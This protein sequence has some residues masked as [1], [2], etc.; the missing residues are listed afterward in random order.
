MSTLI[1]I[2]TYNERENIV[3][4]IR[5]ILMLPAHFEV[6]VVDDNS[7]DGT[8]TAVRETFAAMPRVHMLERAKK[9]GL[10]TAY[11]AGFKFAIEKGY[12]NAITMDADFSHSPD[13]IPHLYDA[14]DANDLVIGSRYVPGGAT[15]NWGILR[16]IISRSANLMAHVVLS[17][18]PADCTSGFRLYRLE[19]LKSLDFETVIAD[20]YSYLVEILFR[21][22]RKNV[23]IA[24]VPIT[25]ED[26]RIG[27]S[28]ISR[29]EIFK[30]VETIIRLRLHPPA[31]HNEVAVRV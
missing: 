17:L 5:R 31:I 30:A 13:H 19:A 7:P 10:G 9:L 2:P 22:A 26:R 24:E 15:V 14:S 28:K 27:I 4:L 20:G 3:P 16:K 11:S 12:R 25:F 29:K 21:A 6:L 23:S 1:V 18:K 8:A